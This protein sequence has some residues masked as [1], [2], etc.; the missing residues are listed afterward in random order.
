MAITKR[1]LKQW[2]DDISGYIGDDDLI[3][4]DEGGLCLVGVND[5]ENP[6]SPEPE[7]YIE[8]GGVPDD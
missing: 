7:I 2:L 6:F 1:E 4:I 5:F 3:G 8:V